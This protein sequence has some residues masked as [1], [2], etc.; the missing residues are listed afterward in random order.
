MLLTITSNPLHSIEQRAARWIL[1]YLD[2]ID[3][4]DLRLTHRELR[5]MLGVRRS[6]IT[7]ALHSFEVRGALRR[8]QGRLRILER[9]ILAE[10]AAPTCRMPRMV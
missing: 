7:E 6:G 9:R 2:R 5:A 4:T 3:G 10:L 1:H 8:R